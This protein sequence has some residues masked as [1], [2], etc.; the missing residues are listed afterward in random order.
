MLL[1]YKR[2]L[3]AVRLNAEADSNHQ[4]L[5]VLQKLLTGT[6]VFKMS[7]LHCKNGNIG[8]NEAGVQPNTSIT[9][10]K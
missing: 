9:W 2:P 10:M 1:A 8:F 3:A 6:H 7:T 4:E 5:L